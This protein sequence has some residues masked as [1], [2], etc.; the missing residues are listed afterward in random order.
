MGRQKGVVINFSTNLKSDGSN[1]NIMVQR[2][3]TFRMVCV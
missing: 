1:R 3:M 2:F